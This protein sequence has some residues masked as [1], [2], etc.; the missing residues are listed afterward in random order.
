MLNLAQPA[1]AAAR[2][3]SLLPLLQ[4]LAA[5]SARA[6]ALPAPV[7]EA[8]TRLLA[9]RVPLDRGAPGADALRQAVNRAGVLGAAA[10]PGGTSSNVKSAL[11]QLRAGLLAMLGDG[12]IAPVAPVARRAPPPMRDAQP[13]GL[14]ADLPT[15]PDTAAPRDTARTLLHQTDSALSRLKLTQMASQ[16]ADARPGAPPMLDLTVEIPMMMGQ[17]L[18]LAQLQVQRDGKSKGKASER[19]WRLRFAVNFS[20]VGEVGAQV[21]LLGASTS[22]VLWAAEE[23]TA[24]VLEE[25]LPDLGTAL[26]ARGLEVGSV[27]LRRGVPKESA[28]PSGRLMDAVR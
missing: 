15:L 2:Q 18:A 13:R 6:V 10:T 4:N 25:M 26:A 21:S 16:P 28:P 7:A 3:D 8:A 23:E 19:G 5:L 27:R 12:E 24:A 9:Q 1:Q 17:E 14:R 20:V 11:L 22:V